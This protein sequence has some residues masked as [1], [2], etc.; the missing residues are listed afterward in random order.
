VCYWYGWK[1]LDEWDLLGDDFIGFRP[2]VQY[3][4]NLNISWGNIFTHANP[5]WD[6]EG[7][8]SIEGKVKLSSRS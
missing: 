3:T 6:S 4:K 8:P 2:M 1:A 7:G 5:H